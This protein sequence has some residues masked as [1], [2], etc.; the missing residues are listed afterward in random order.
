MA[1]L[2]LLP[3]AGYLWWR[4]IQAERDLENASLEQLR[5]ITSER[6]GYTRAFYYL[7]LRLEHAQH[8]ALAFE[9]L[10]RAAAL[11][12]DDE[13][14]WIA[15][16][17]AANGLNGPAASLRLMDEFLKRH[18]DSAG[19]KAQR[20][21]LL[22]SLQRAADDFAAAKH[23]KEAVRC[24]LIRLA[25]EPSAASAQQGLIK[26]L[27]ADGNDEETF[28]TLDRMVQQNP[29]FVEAH[30][31]LA[32]LFLAAGFHKE[33][34]QHLEEAVKQ[35]P[36]NAKA[37]H[38]L[39]RV[40]GGSDLDVAENALQKAVDLA[41]DNALALLDLAAIQ[42]TKAKSVQAEMN[43]RQALRLAPKTPVVLAQV[44]GFLLAAHPD[45][46]HV[47]EAERLARQALILDPQNGDAHYALGRVALGRHEAGQAVSSLEK[48]I[49]YPLTEE[50]GAAWY[51]LS[52]A[53]IL[54]GDQTRAAAARRKA[55]Q[56]HAAKFA[57]ARAEEEAY[58]RPQDPA[59]RLKVARLYAQH[60]VY[61]KAISQYQGCLTLDPNNVMARNEL[62][63]LTAH[64]KASGK[65]PSMTL[66]Q[67]MVAASSRLP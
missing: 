22:V 12:L 25:E 10:S 27:Q 58:I 32:D 51:T 48:A 17:D 53:Y 28:L 9:A 29:Q 55:Q 66:F 42:V 50:E 62:E 21:S 36:N 35:A 64:L 24:Y 8:Q 60:G 41:P 38:M 11:D 46:V 52:R 37:W 57:L 6:P 19:M 49:M 7:G 65:L 33:A 31:I 1:L 18:P 43:Y 15:A 14:V 5:K 54:Q 16:S 61:V 45:A 20:A 67:A 56:I 13:K 4:P 26:A 39:G 40:A 47:A 23:N 30:I 44:S 59:L 3:L 2:L 34:R 63:T